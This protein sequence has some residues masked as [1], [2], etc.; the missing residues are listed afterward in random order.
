MAVIAEYTRDTGC[1]ITVRDDYIRPSEE[2]KKI[3]ERMSQIVIDGERRR[4]YEAQKS[5][6]EPV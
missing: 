5:K 3:I 4:A 1:K 6:D 2:V